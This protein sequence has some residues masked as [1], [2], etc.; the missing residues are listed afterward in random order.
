MPDIRTAV[1]QARSSSSRRIAA[2][3]FT[4][5][6]YAVVPFRHLDYFHDR[7]RLEAMFVDG[8]LEPR[9][10]ALDHDFSRPGLG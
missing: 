4:P 6:L 1:C 2:L 9:R 8:V 3:R 10:G 5:T 7:V